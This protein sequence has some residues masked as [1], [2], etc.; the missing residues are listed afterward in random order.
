MQ[1]KCVYKTPML[2]CAWKVCLQNTD[3][4]ILGW[5][6]GKGALHAYMPFASQVQH[7]RKIIIENVTM[8]L[9]A[10]TFLNEYTCAHN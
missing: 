7:I 3:T 4:S 2:R 10:I 1:G 6:G 8:I 9:A 5:D